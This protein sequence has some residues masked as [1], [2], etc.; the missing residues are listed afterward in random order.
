LYVGAISDH[1]RP[2]YG[3]AEA[4]RLGMLGLLPFIFVAIGAHLV[5]ARSMKRE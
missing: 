2:E 1:F 4:L 3:A 5:A